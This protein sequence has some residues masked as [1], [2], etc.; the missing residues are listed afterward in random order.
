MEM[1]IQVH[2]LGKEDAF[3]MGLPLQDNEVLIG[4]TA[5]LPNGE[6]YVADFGDGK[7]VRSYRRNDWEE[8]E[9]SEI[10]MFRKSVLK[11][12]HGNN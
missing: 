4:M 9:E 10:E 7:T 1:D 8:I 6:K 2:K 11:I 5:T 12:S 3:A